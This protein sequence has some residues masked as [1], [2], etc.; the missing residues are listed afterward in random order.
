MGF[1]WDERYK[2]KRKISQM[3]FGKGERRIMVALLKKPW[4]SGVGGL[5][6]AKFLPEDIALLVDMDTEQ[7]SDYFLAC[8]VVLKNAGKTFIKMSPEVFNGIKRS[9]PIGRFTLLHELGHYV[10]GDQDK[11]DYK[12]EQYDKIRGNAIRA[13]RVLD[14][15]LNADKFAYDYLGLDYCLEALEE[16]EFYGDE[17]EENGRLHI[18][19]IE[20]RKEYLKTKGWERK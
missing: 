15:E 10:N 3:Y 18:A 7:R 8:L 2:M 4:T 16:L 11:D 9:W 1:V 12:G 19:E 5:I 14:I 20:M 13:G 17:E 6:H